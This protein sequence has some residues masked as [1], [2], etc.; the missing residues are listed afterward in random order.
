MPSS[1]LGDNGSEESG[2]TSSHAI[3]PNWPPFGRRMAMAVVQVIPQQ[4]RQLNSF[5]KG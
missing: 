2:V 3:L 1:K 5:Q 4:S